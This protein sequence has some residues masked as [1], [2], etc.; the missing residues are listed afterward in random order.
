VFDAHSPV[1][2]T[3]LGLAGGRPDTWPF[4]LGE[5]RQSAPARRPLRAPRRIVR[6]DA[7]PD[8][9]RKSGSDFGT[10]DEAGQ[11]CAAVA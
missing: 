11:S 7:R 1:E 3:E 8:R 6:H 9:R 5:G 2:L 10:A 4:T